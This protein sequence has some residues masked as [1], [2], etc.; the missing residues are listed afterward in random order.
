MSWMVKVAD[1]Q[2]EGRGEPAPVKCPDSDYAMAIVIVGFAF[3]WAAPVV[4]YKRNRPFMTFN[5]EWEHVEGRAEIV[6]LMERIAGDITRMR[7][8]R[9]R[10]RANG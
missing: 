4:L 5:L 6:A 2:G 3:A 1:F 8:L 10:S 7:K 9:E